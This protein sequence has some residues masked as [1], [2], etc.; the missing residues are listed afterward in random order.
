MRSLLTPKRRQLKRSALRS[1]DAL[2][3]AWRR[4][5]GAWSTNEMMGLSLRA[6]ALQQ[7]LRQ[8]AIEQDAMPTGVV[9]VPRNEKTHGFTVDLEELRRIAMTPRT[10]K[11]EV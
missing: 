11:K 10:G 1:I 6:G 4:K 9:K 5:T 7:T 2:V 3:E 8:M